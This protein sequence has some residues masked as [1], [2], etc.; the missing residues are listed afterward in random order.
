VN[1]YSV[2]KNKYGF[3]S[4]QPVPSVDE[5]RKH[6]EDMYYQKA[7]GSY[8]RDY[9]IDEL[10]YFKSEAAISEYIFS[11]MNKSFSRK[12]LDVGAGEG[13]FSKYFLEKDWDI[14][15][16]DYSNFGMKRNNPQL[17]PTLIQGDALEVLSQLITDKKIFDFINLK[18][19]L[20]HSREPVELL[21]KI[22]LLMKGGSLLRIEVPNDYSSFQQLLLDRKFSPNTWFSP[23]EHLHYFNANSLV[24]FIK[25]LGFKIHLVLSDFPI[26][27]FLLN[28]NS[29]YS[30]DKSL[31]KGAHRARVTANNFILQSG[32]EKYI[33]YYSA[34][35]E[36]GLG[37]QI[38]VFATVE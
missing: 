31:G 18:N 22:K 8:Q 20:E 38:I 12:L 1:K 29:N 16:T 24:D 10:N 30:R 6:Y 32:F 21:Q 4:I 25:C 37:R 2:T 17:I 14:A 15:T 19:V 5:L 7:S 33:E 26:E 36:V 35:A 9:E 27:L 28:E 13:Y 34:S 11:C 23:P 3:Y